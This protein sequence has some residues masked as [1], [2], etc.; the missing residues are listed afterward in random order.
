M[1]T[2]T[3]QMPVPSQTSVFDLEEVLKM[4]ALCNDVK[5]MEL[6]MAYFIKDCEKYLESMN[7]HCLNFS[8]SLHNHTFLSFSLKKIIS[9]ENWKKKKQ[10]TRSSNCSALKKKNLPYGEEPLQIKNISDFEHIVCMFD[11]VC[12][13]A[14]EVLSW[15]V[16][17]AILKAVK[18]SEKSK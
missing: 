10:F 9:S 1:S 7:I 6:G 12:L 17:I 13:S 18:L 5:S 3:K 2:L 11:Q 15:Y 14:L 4:F 8:P 16:A